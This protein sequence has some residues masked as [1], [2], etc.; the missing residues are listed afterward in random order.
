[1]VCFE[2][3]VL[4]DSNYYQLIFIFIVESM[5]YIAVLLS[6][7]WLLFSCSLYA[8]SIDDVTD[9][10]YDTGD[11]DI[12]G[13]DATEIGQIIKEDSIDADSADGDGVVLQIMAAFG[14]DYTDQTDQTATFYVKEIINWLLAIIGLVALIS[15]LWWFYKMLLAKDSEE[16]YTSA[17][18]IVSNAALALVIIGISWFLVSWFFSIYS[19]T[20]STTNWT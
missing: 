15:M 8:F 1:M 7:L 13:A 11:E 2:F 20:L 6:C 12:S 4:V 9:F 10:P 14:I 19:A 18:K 3:G 17:K 5:K 16:W